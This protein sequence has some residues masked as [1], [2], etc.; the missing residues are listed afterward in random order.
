GGEEPEL[1]ARDPAELLCLEHR[2]KPGRV[3]EG[4]LSEVDGDGVRRLGA[5]NPAD[6]VLDKVSRRDVELAREEEAMLVPADGVFD[7]E[8]R[9]LESSVRNG[10]RHFLPPPTRRLKGGP[11]RSGQPRWCHLL[12][13]ITGPPR[14]L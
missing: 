6:H 8:I 11:H 13:N 9:G 5:A 12:S 2:A 1:E 7:L 3:H 14:S 10:C 4:D